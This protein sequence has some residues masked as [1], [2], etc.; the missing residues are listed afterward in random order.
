MIR[1]VVSETLEF[2]DNLYVVDDGSVDDT[3]AQISD[4]PVNLLQ[5]DKNRGKAASLW[6]GIQAALADGAEAVITL[7]ADGQHLPAD[8]PRFIQAGQEYPDT[9]IIGSRLA[10]KAAFPAKRYYANQVANFWISWAAGYPISDSQSG[11]RLYPAT[12]LKKLSMNTEKDRSFVFESEILIKAAR[13]GIRSQPI[14]IK[15]IYEAD[16]RPSHFRSV[17]DIVRITQM[18]AWKLIS[19]GFYPA[20]LFN[21]LLGTRFSRFSKGIIGNDGVAMLLLS[22]LTIPTSGGITLLW[23]FFKVLQTAIRSPAEVHDPSWLIVLGMRLHYG[24]L[25]SDYQRRLQRAQAIMRDNPS[26]QLLILGGKTGG[27]DTSEAE[28]GQFYLTNQGIA[29]ERIKIEDRSLHTLENLKAARDMLSEADAKGVVLITNRY[30]LARSE[31]MAKGFAVQPVLCAAESR[32]SPGFHNLLCILKEAF[33]LHWYYT[34][35]LYARL[36]GNQKMLDRIS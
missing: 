24:S 12:L 25:P 29:K 22:T 15:A 14:P 32:F 31:A 33:L 27:N 28:M 34:G 10:D 13:L 5:N 20:G 4:L 16:A 2:C 26:V 1:K 18:V 7:D 19:R 6:R 21:V 30:H 35:S 23:V 17:R 9:I 8:I 11:F 36:S 3:A